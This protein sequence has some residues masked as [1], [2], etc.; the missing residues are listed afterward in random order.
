MKSLCTPINFMMKTFFYVYDLFV[1]FVVVVVVVMISTLKAF[2]L[3]KSR[4]L[5]VIDS[6]KA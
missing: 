2:S 6:S 1:V 3:L 4:Y 5:Q